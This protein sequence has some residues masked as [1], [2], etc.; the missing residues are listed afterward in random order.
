MVSEML[1]RFFKGKLKG[2]QYHTLQVARIDGGTTLAPVDREHPNK[3]MTAV[4]QISSIN[5]DH[6]NNKLFKKR[7]CDVHE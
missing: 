2:V 4:R 7:D 6:S 1:L 5:K 3:P